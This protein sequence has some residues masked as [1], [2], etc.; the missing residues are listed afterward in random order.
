MRCR[1]TAGAARLTQAAN[2]YGRGEGGGIVVL[3]RLADAQADG[4]MILAVVHG[5]A[6][7]HDGQS[8]G[9]TAPNGQ[10]QIELLQQALGNAN[11]APQD[12]QVIE[13]HGTG[14]PLGDPI[15]VNALSHVYLKDREAPLTL[16][17]VKANI[18][19]LEGAAGIA[20]FI[21]MVIALQKRKSLESPFRDT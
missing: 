10:A 5:S 12:V 11:L 6:A 14:T 7:N 1:P 20:G 4:D 3:K 13:A 9:L 18:G 16:G 15:E 21:K 8:N 19:H 2:G 17:T